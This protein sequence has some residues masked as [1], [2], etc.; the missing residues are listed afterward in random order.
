MLLERLT[1]TPEKDTGLLRD[2]MSLNRELNLQD[3]NEVM[4]EL[5]RN[6]GYR[7]FKTIE[8]N[9]N[10]WAMQADLVKSGTGNPYRIQIFV[11]INE[12][13]NVY[14]QVEIVHKPEKTI[15]LQKGNFKALE[16]LNVL[17]SLP[18]FPNP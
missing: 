10:R 8:G 14:L 9:P 7:T 5:I 4:T 6:L 11:N 3:T 18:Y 1:L 2:T 16:V 12:I 17:R 15:V 13:D